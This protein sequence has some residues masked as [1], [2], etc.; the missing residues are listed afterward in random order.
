MPNRYP[1]FR[2]GSQ[3]CSQ[4]TP[5]VKARNGK[6]IKM[7]NL[8]FAW[9]SDPAAYSMQTAVHVFTS[10]Q[11]Y[12]SSDFTCISF[13]TK[14]FKCQIQIC[15]LNYLC[16]KWVINMKYLTYSDF[17]NHKTIS[18]H[19]VSPFEIPSKQVR[20]KTWDATCWITLFNKFP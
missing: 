8:K 14:A 10:E 15:V 6:I 19:N 11:G 20:T 17:N 7:L 4:S 13:Y 16:H 5:L 18:L 9:I 12:F 3:K 1:H 2:G